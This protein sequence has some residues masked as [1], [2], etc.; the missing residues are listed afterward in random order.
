MLPVG[1]LIVTNR[2]E[3]FILAII[4]KS[5]WH[6]RK[7]IKKFQCRTRRTKVLLLNFYAAIKELI[8]VNIIFSGK[9]WNSLFY[10]ALV[11]PRLTYRIIGIMCR[12]SISSSKFC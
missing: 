1:I 3:K 10:G 12:G 11:K 6:K 9:C 8:V 4:L 2:R 5:F 7:K